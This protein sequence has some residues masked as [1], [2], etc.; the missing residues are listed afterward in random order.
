MIDFEALKAQYQL[1]PARTTKWLYALAVVFLIV[2]LVG[3]SHMSGKRENNPVVGQESAS[4]RIF[5]NQGTDTTQQ[6]PTGA[7]RRDALSTRPE[8][9]TSSP[10][11]LTVVVLLL[12]LGG[13]VYVLIGYLRKSVRYRAVAPMGWGAAPSVAERIHQ[14]SLGFSLGRHQ[15]IQVFR[16]GDEVVLVLSTQGVSNTVLKTMTMEEWTRLSGADA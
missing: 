1:N 16:I 7:T 3:Y 9:R 2:T 5:R 15:E 4:E 8:K 11:T 6:G 14:Q 13:S 12:F 10:S